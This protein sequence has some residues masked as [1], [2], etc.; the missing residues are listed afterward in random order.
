[1]VYK[2]NI[3]N[4]GCMFLLLLLHHHAAHPRYQYQSIYSP[5]IT[6]GDP[7][8]PQRDAL[9]WNKYGV[10]L[11]IK[12][13][14]KNRPSKDPKIS[15]II[16]CYYKHAKQLYFLLKMYENQTRLP[17][18]VVISLSETCRIPSAQLAPLKNELW[19]FPVT[20]I[21]S[22]RQQYA[23]ENRNIAC[24]VATGDVFL[25]QDADDV[26]HPQRVEMVHYFF[27]TYN[28]DHLMHRYKMINADDNSISFKH[29]SDFSTIPF[30]HFRTHDLAK[31]AGRLTN[32]N[33]AIARHVFEKLQWE[34][35]PR[36]E[37][38]PFNRTAYKLFRKCI[39]IQATLYGYRQFLSSTTESDTIAREIYIKPMQTIKPEKR[40]RITI[41]EQ[42]KRRYSS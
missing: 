42:R 14:L 18:E 15:V 10:S 41:I 2:Q 26:P 13:T 7:E 27:S 39:V 8:N 31:K 23:G 32:G 33:I 24:S 6:R 30:T 29:Y 34:I 3:T 12:E 37:D 4:L 21:A 1:M 9:Y 38:S 5:K 11:G 35:Q 28:I 22:E 16:P 17:D 36:A 25:C 40:H 19:A 20:L